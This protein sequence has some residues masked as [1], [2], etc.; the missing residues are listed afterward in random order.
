[1]IN[2]INEISYKFTP[3]QQELINFLAY[4]PN[5]TY[6]QIA[7]AFYWKIDTARTYIKQIAQELYIEG[8]GL[9]RQIYDKVMEEKL[10][11]D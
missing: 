5:T 3:K 6:L 1:M 10:T 8:D 4:S 9:I 7:N 11:N 2:D